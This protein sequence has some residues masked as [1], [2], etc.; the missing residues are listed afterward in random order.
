[1]DPIGRGFTHTRDHRLEVSRDGMYLDYLAAK[2]G[3]TYLHP[4]EAFFLHLVLR[5]LRTCYNVGPP[6]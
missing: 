5:K 2:M 1:M 3:R 4:R 6:L